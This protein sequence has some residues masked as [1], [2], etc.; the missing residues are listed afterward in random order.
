ME[1]LPNQDQWQLE[2]K[3][4]QES[5]QTY[6]KVKQENSDLM[7]QIKVNS[8]QLAD[9]YEKFEQKKIEVNNGLQLM[10]KDNFN[11]NKHNLSLA[12]GDSDDST[13]S[14]KRVKTGEHSSNASGANEAPLSPH[15]A[16]LVEDLRNKHAHLE[17]LQSEL[18]SLS[19]VIQCQTGANN[20]QMIL[21][22]AGLRQNHQVIFEF[23]TE[24]ISLKSVKVKVGRG[25]KKSLN[26]F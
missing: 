26:M 15:S 14:A 9:L 1:L 13:S 12:A 21:K 5:H 19:G 25:K 2:E 10:K 8:K 7:N 16:I 6:K 4:S 11:S 24:S 23:F 18:Q 20:L 17:K 22:Q 3:I